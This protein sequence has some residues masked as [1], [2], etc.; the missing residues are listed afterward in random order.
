VGVQVGVH[1]AV[2]FRDAVQV[3]LGRLNAGDLAGSECLGE[4]GRG[5]PDDVAGCHLGVLPQDLW[6]PDSS[7]L[8]GGRL[9][10]AR[11]DR[12][13]AADHVLAHDVRHRERVAGCA[14]VVTGDFG[15]RGHR[16]DDHVQVAGQLLDLLVGQVDPG[17][18][19]QACN[20]VRVDGG[21]GGEATDVTGAFG[22]HSGGGGGSGVRPWGVVR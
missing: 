3:G 15:D 1:L 5:Q 12:Q 18:G 11:T 2:D 21:H 6:Y 10:E 22:A 4:F 14:H 8:G 17:Q 19:G 13:G 20:L 16:L 7:V 9:V